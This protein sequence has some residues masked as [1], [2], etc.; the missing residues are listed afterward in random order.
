MTEHRSIVSELPDAPSVARN[1]DVI[2]QVM[3]RE[4]SAACRVLE[5]GSGTGQHAVHFAAA[6]P[7]VTW[8]TSELLEHHVG[9]RQWIEASGL[10]NVLSPM[11]LDVSSVTDINAD[12]AAVFSA[13]TSHIMSAVS[14]A[15]MMALAA[16][17]LMPAGK[18][19]LYG[20]FRIAG[21]FTS[22]SNEAF[23]KWLKE[24]DPARGI[25]DLEW[26]DDIGEKQQLKRVKTYAMP[27]NNMLV[28]WQ[29]EQGETDDDNS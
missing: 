27:A 1:R 28:V 5:I 10:D 17:A 8:Q 29:K 20:P 4:L 9:I 2:L 13:N 7:Q 18:F 14:A 24:Q 3:R 11:V 19:L 12:Y 21:R 6:L 23:D 15:D 25:R 22:E 26:L 16:Q